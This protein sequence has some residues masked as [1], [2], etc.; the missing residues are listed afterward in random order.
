MTEFTDVWTEMCYGRRQWGLIADQGPSTHP[1]AGNGAADAAGA[2]QDFDGISYTK[3]S[4]V[5]RQLAASVG[6][7]VFFGGVADHLERHRFGNATLHDIV[8]SWEKAGAPDL[9]DFVREWLLSPGPDLLTWD[10]A[11]MVLRRQAPPGAPAYRQHTFR[12]AVFDGSWRSET[13]SV[14][15]PETPFAPR[16]RVVLLDPWDDTWAV[17]LPDPETVAALPEVLTTITDGH[18]RAGVWNALRSAFHNAL[19]DPASVIDIAASS[20]PVEDGEEHPRRTQAWLLGRV[21]PL[22]P[23]GSEQR[24]HDAAVSHLDREPGSERQLGAFRLAVA[25]ATSPDRLRDWLH[26]PPPGIEVDRATQWRL[27]VRLAELG[28]ISRAE[29]RAA[30]EAEPAADAKVQLRRALAALPDAAA[31]AEAWAVFTGETDVPNYEIEAAALGMWQGP[32]EVTAPYVERYFA[33]L[34]GTTSVRSGWVLADAA[35]WFFPFCSVSTDTVARAEALVDQLDGS[36]RRRVLDA[37]DLLRRQLAVRLAYP[38]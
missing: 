21:L 35:E 7:E 4:A 18:L 23:A 27:R 6:D 14:R 31:K 19:L 26:S 8:C 24:L 38:C 5:L 25:T 10:R 15:G 32:A 34:P 9:H 2:L 12:T 11:A 33:E 30:L 22:A 16:G 37:T 28:A 1:V 29:M 17:S 36:L 13:V 3:G 20:P